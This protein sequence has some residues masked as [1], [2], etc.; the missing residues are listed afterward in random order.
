MS[1]ESVSQARIARLCRRAATNMSLDLSGMCVLTEAATGPFAA[2]AAVA[3]LAGADVVAVAK[4]SPWGSAAEAFA[5]T[6]AIAALL[7]CE[8]S[9]TFSA[10][11]SNK[12]RRSYDL[13]TNLGFV[14]PIDHTI[15]ELLSPEATVSLMWEP[16]EFRDA[17]IDR[18]A[19]LAAGVPLVAT[20][21]S[22][23]LVRT[24]SYLGPTVGRLL[25]ES[26]IEIVGSNI[27]LVGSD[28]FGAAILEWLETAGAFVR[29][30][31]LADW[32]LSVTSMVEIDA[33]VVVEHRDHRDMLSFPGFAAALA[34]LAKVGAPVVRLCGMLDR[35]QVNAAGGAIVPA[36]DASVGV[37]SVTTAFAGPRPVIDLHSAGLKAASVVVN[38]RRSGLSP[39]EAIEVSIASGFGLAVPDQS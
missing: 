30:C 38:A 4:D 28:P 22:H 37:M 23:P 5:A 25:L 39:R 18:N 19:L 6:K 16:W 35:H 14:R 13:V 24:L 15:V 36:V 12:M 2:T 27:L 31:A 20:N 33:L 9:I 32:A 7:D 11:S 10:V 26:K 1:D 8:N 17:D 21:E 3:A 29:R 34:I